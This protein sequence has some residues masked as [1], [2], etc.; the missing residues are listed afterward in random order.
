MPGIGRHRFEWV[1]KP[2]MYWTVLLVAFLIYAALWL[3]DG[4]WLPHFVSGTPSAQHAYA[5]TVHGNSGYVTSWLGW[6][7]EKGDSMFWV[8][9]G[10]LALVMFLKRHQVRKVQ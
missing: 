8:F 9:L 4:F 10:T 1:D 6:F 3:L 2:P 7:Y 5:I